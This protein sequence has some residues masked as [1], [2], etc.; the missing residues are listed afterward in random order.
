MAQSIKLGKAEKEYIRQIR[1]SLPFLT[2]D[3]DIVRYSLST[4][5]ERLEYVD[6]AERLR[7]G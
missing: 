3:I 6:A 7:K 4:T 2:K 1:K 5:K